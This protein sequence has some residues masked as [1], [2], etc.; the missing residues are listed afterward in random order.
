TIGDIGQSIANMSPEALAALGL[1]GLAG[2][3]GVV[4]DDAEGVTALAHN[5]T[6]G[7]L[8]NIIVNT[9]SGRDLS[10]DTVLTLDLHGFE[11]V[12]NSMRA[13]SFGILLADAAR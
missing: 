8:Q 9:A 13:D 11:A 4:I 7:S 1:S 3:H 5:V 6:D 2:A 12:Q 10:L